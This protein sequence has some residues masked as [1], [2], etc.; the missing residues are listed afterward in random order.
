M[1]AVYLH[2]STEDTLEDMGTVKVENDLFIDSRETT[3][4]SGG[5]LKLATALESGEV[6][7]A[8][9]TPKVSLTAFLLPEL[10]TSASISSRSTTL[11][12]LHNLHEI[13]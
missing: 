4:S 7:S 2:R 13:G 11:H 12:N 5:L 8:T 6:G 9:T 1:R 10:A 3:A